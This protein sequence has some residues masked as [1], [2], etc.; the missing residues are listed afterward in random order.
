MKS[1][2]QQWLSAM[3][4]PSGSKTG[5]LQRVRLFCCD[6]LLVSIADSAGRTQ[7]SETG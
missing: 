1:D 3:P 6:S 7:I 4:N 5:E 2:P